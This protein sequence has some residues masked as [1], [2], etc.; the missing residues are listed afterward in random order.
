[1][2]KTQ[3]FW[4]KRNAEKLLIIQADSLVIKPIDNSF[5]SYDYI[6]APWNP[7]RH[8]STDFPVYSCTNRGELLRHQWETIQFNPRLDPKWTY[9]NG[10]LSIRSSRCMAQICKSE[11]SF[12]EEP[13]D[14]FFSRHIRN[15]SNNIATLE[16]AERFSCESRYTE[17]TGTH[18]SHLY[19]EACDQG[20][21][22][23]RHFKSVMGLINSY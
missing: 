13:E 5:F 11:E 7:G 3:E 10:G 6:G 15:Y 20:K 23:E 8:V 4:T 2:L 14:V 17:S 22:Y 9:G 21:I 1:M 12:P 16:T 19:L 18:A